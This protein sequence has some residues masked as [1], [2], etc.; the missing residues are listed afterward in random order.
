MPI[1]NILD[2]NGNFVPIPAIV[3]PQGPKGETGPQGPEGP[4]GTTFETDETLSLEGGVLSVN[5]AFDVEE[6]NT[7]PVTSAAVA[8]T[9]GNIEILLSTI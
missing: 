8:A 6:D 4:Q 9:V 1:L 7:L 2:E 3:G 5:R